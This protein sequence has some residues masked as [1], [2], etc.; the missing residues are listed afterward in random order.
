MVGRRSFAQGRSGLPRRSSHVAQLFSLGGFDCMKTTSRV[1]GYFA[2]FFAVA[3]W[4][5]AW[6]ANGNSTGH[7]FIS[8][9]LGWWIL[10]AAIA[11]VVCLASAGLGFIL[12]LRQDYKFIK[13]ALD[14]EKPSA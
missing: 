2:S 10:L 9:L 3:F 8:D 11:G 7:D 13:K 4:V 12:S 6:L 14:D 1:A 5:T